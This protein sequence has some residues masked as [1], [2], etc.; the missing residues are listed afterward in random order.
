VICADWSCVSAGKPGREYACVDPAAV[1][2]VGDG[3]CRMD[4]QCV[5][6]VRIPREVSELD[7]G[8]EKESWRSRAER[9]P[10]V[11][12]YVK[13]AMESCHVKTKRALA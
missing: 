9:L 10:A 8:F 13:R 4:V 6:K 3:E 1:G 7:R 11:G 5:S 2:S 12:D